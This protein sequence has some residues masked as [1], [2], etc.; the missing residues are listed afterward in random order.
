[1]I[2]TREIVSFLPLTNNSVTI[3]LSLSLLSILALI[4]SKANALRFL[5]G[6]Y[7]SV[8]YKYHPYH[9]SNNPRIINLNCPGVFL[10]DDT[11][12]SINPDRKILLTRN[13]AQSYFV[14]LKKMAEKKF[15]NFSNRDDDLTTYVN[16]VKKLCRKWVKLVFFLKLTL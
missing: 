5:F 6:L 1:M 2:K 11:P 12:G 15:Q 3:G 13:L 14:M 7:S 16:F 4:S 8:F 9:L 10:S